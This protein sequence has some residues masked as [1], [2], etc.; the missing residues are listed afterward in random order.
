M[1]KEADATALERKAKR[2]ARREKERQENG[3][4]AIKMHAA[5]IKD[6]GELFEVPM[7]MQ[8]YYIGCYGWFYLNWG[9]IFILIPYSKEELMVWAHRIRE[10]RAKRVWVY[11][12]NDNEGYAIQ[13]AKTLNKRLRRLNEN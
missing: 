6:N 2:E 10:C 3:V 12:N 5:R 4:R 13:N 1:A 9:G 7:L 8:R 11:F